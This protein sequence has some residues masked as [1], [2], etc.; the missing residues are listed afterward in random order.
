MHLW[1]VSERGISK[2]PLLGWG[3]NG[4]GTAYAHI[5]SRKFMPKVLHL[6]EF[7]FDYLDKNGKI[8]TDAL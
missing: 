3:M 6:G 2:R 7:T 5:R 8:R 1:E 4:F